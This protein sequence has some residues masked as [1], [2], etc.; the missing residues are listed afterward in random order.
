MEDSLRFNQ[1]KNK[2]FEHPSL[3]Q[4]DVEICGN[5]VCEDVHVWVKPERR[6]DA[7][8]LRCLITGISYTH[9]L[10]PVHLLSH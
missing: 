10:L 6:Q 2:F 4:E 1:D 8:Q 5:S 7:G 9:I 3:W